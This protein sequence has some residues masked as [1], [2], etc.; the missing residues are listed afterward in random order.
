MRVRSARV[1]AIGVGLALF[2]LVAAGPP[3][4]SVGN[5]RGPVSGPPAVVSLGDSFISGEAGR[6]R[7]NGDTVA[8]S[9]F[10]T[11]LAAY[12]C[13]A[14]ESSCF[15]NPGRVYGASYVNGC[16]RSKRA[17]ITHLDRVTVNGATHGIT[18]GNRIN[19]A[20][21]DATTANVMNTAFKGER[22]QVEQLA[23]WAGRR[24]VKLIVLSI[25]GNDLGFG[26]IIA[27][28]VK[29]YITPVRNWHCNKT[30]GPGLSGRIKR[31]ERAT[32]DT[33]GAIRRTMTK[34]G[35]SPDA[36]RLV[37]QSYP[38]I[39][40]RGADNRY[41][42]ESYERV[43]Y[44][45]CPFFN[46]DSDWA[47]DTVV[48]AIGD[49]L[50]R[51]ATGAGVGY[52][53]MRHALDGHEVCASGV[54]QS[55]KANTLNKPLPAE[56]AEWVRFVVSGAGQGQQQESLHPNAHGQAKL[57]TCLR[58]FAVRPGKSYGCPA[59]V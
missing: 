35:Y 41:E 47:H 44:G 23:T 38:S 55:K 1:G 52:L 58:A 31:M 29:G 13:D 19:L 45:G 50:R 3:A 57:G 25:G 48:P 20:C 28:C 11:D 22:P 7:G 49:A 37:V 26:D 5:A 43:R 54:G 9:R 53:D 4:A 32:A 17:E 30:L 21:S 39:L 34:A 42:R 6:W 16:N 14:T 8:G 24:D 51:V 10:G 12:N 27:D 2:A 33:V 15:Y 56:S 40:P 46:D 36:Y 59:T 18:P